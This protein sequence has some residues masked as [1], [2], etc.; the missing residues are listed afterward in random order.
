VL[1]ASPLVG[2]LADRF[3][4]RRVALTSVVLFSLSFM[5]F[6]LGTGSITLFYL[7]WAVMALAGAGTLPITWTRAVNN[8][9]DVHKGLALGLSLVGTGIFGF[10]VKP[11]TAWLIAEHGW[12]SA[13]VVVGTLPLLLAL[14][15]ALLAF[16]DVGQS[17]ASAAERRAADA[18]R[19]AAAPGLTFRETL[20]EYRFWL[21]A[22]CFVLVSFAVGGLIPNMENILKV[23]GFSRGD[24]VALVTLIGLSVTVGRIAGGWLID[25]FWAP[26]VACVMISLPAL[27]CYLLAGGSMS[28]D[29]ARL[30]IVL[31][32]IAAGVEYDLMAFLVARYFG[33]KSYGAIYGALYGCFAFG[34]GLA[35]VV[36]GKV[37]DK[38]GSY[39]GVLLLS[40]AFLVVGALAL[41]GLGRYRK[42][43]A[44]A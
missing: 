12:R 10:L 30:A 23:A 40:A 4:V 2:L 25:R 22:F 44:R 1:V 38:T 26:G 9:F 41:L 32:G 43:E 27:A 3:G 7:N 36:F 20:R 21:L 8:R 18:L 39:D 31:V 28:I 14:P 37:F 35:P 11:L 29:A 13:Y 42:F 24:V 33:M 5:G 15:V 34:A 16:H 6:A 19:A 17:G